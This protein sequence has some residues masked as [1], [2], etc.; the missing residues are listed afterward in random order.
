MLWCYLRSPALLGF[1][2]ATLRHGQ[3]HR[4]GQLNPLGPSHVA[5]KAWQLAQG[6][7]RSPWATSTRA[8]GHAGAGVG[9]WAAGRVLPAAP[10]PDSL[11][12][13]GEAGAGHA[14]LRGCCITRRHRRQ[15]PPIPASCLPTGF[16]HPCR[17]SERTEE[18]P[19]TGRAAEEGRQ[20]EAPVSPPP[21]LLTPGRQPEAFAAAG[22]A[23]PSSAPQARQAGGKHPLRGP[24]GFLW[25]QQVGSNS[26]GLHRSSSWC[27]GPPPCPGAGTHQPC[28]DFGTTTS[29]PPPAPALSI[30]SKQKRFGLRHRCLGA[31][32]PTLGGAKRTNHTASRARCPEKP[33]A[34]ESRATGGAEL[35][36]PRGYRPVCPAMAGVGIARA[37]SLPG[38]WAGL[39]SR[40]LK[41]QSRF[42]TG[43]FISGE[44]GAAR[45]W[46]FC[47]LGYLRRCSSQHQGCR[48]RTRAP[49]QR[50]GLLNGAEMGDNTTTT[51]NPPPLRPLPA[52]Y[53]MEGWRYGSA[54]LS[55]MPTQEGLHHL[56]CEPG[57]L[58]PEL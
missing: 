12:G 20:L 3:K 23:K 4:E 17:R 11:C 40:R 16:L 1:P 5:P 58:I 14:A 33:L 35:C 54:A 52:R 41:P 49:N 26:W 34:G 46:L 53:V 51:T 27:G 56:S 48:A 57:I 7:A 9:A 47:H 37:S 30:L 21:P 19:S 25:E 13:R 36:Q 18:K 22:V 28:W 39:A 8:I 29:S 45:C 6:H 38:S 44:S 31:L 24:A 43:T 2:G 32:P 15:L 10:E 55:A 42:G 50:R